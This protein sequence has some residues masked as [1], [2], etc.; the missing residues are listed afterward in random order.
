MAKG[1]ALAGAAVTNQFKLVIDGLP[2]IYFIRIGELAREIGISELADDTAQTTGR[3]PTG[4][5][6]AAQYVH[7]VAEKDAMWAWHEEVEGG[8]PG[9]KKDGELHHLDGGGNPKASWGLFGIMNRGLKS[10]ELKLG[11][12]GD[13]VALTWALHYDDWRP[14]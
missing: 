9:Y 11:E 3:V 2:D 14:I 13:N 10:P 5:T 6:E 4:E 8:V 12:D 1:Q 7:H